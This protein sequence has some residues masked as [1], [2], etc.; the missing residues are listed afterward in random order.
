[1][2]NIRAKIAYEGTAFYGWQLQLDQPTIQ[3]TLQ[4]VL[5]EIEGQP[6]EVAGSGRT[7]AGVHALGQVASF[8]LGNPIPMENLKMILRDLRVEFADEDLIKLAQKYGHTPMHPCT[9]TPI[10]T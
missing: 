9:H 5:A 3:G 1:M 4:S 6:V 10:H 2:K 7:D 8:K